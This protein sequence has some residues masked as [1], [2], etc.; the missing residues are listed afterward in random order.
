MPSL[1]TN[2]KSTPSNSFEVKMKSEVTTLTGV[3]FTQT[4]I[5]SWKQLTSTGQLPIKCT[6]IQHHHLPPLLPLPRY[7]HLDLFADLSGKYGIGEY[8]T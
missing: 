6:E 4:L 1:K 3:A 8:I 5:V 7:Y 2:L